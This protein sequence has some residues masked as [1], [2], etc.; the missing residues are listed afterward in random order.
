MRSRVKVCCIASPEEASLAVPNGAD[1]LGLVGAIPSGPGVVDDAI[2]A[3]HV[4]GMGTTAVQ[5]V[6][7]IPP[8]ESA[9]LAALLPVTR[10]VQVIH[11]EDGAALDLI[12]A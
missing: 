4:A 8:A 7:H 11:V 6:S 1:A 3:R 5:I 12:E 9:R 2:I 10:R